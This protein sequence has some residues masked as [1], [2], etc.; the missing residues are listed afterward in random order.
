MFICGIQSS[1]VP[2]IKLARYTVERREMMKLVN[3]Q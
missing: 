3:M 2:V 1:T